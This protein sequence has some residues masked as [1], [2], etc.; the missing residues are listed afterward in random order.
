MASPMQAK[1][2]KQIEETVWSNND[3]FEN[4]SSFPVTCADMKSNRIDNIK[5]A[6]EDVKLHDRMLASDLEAK[7]ISIVGNESEIINQQSVPTRI[8]SGTEEL[9]IGGTTATRSLSGHLI[10]EDA[11]L[12]G[13]AALSGPIITSG[14]IPYSGNISLRSDSSTTSTRSFAFPILQSDWSSSPV[15]MAKAERKHSWKHR[16]RAALTCCK[17]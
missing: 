15:K 5:G 3:L 10:H 7:G 4:A 1:E 12:P 8:G 13:S 11:S 16:W 14:H 17:F 9:I 6:S 2:C